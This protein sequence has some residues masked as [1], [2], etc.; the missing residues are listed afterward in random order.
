VLDAAAAAGG[1][2]QDP[3]LL[4]RRTILRKFTGEQVNTLLGG[5]A[6]GERAK[7]LKSLGCGGGGPCELLLVD[8]LLRPA[9][10]A[11]LDAGLHAGPLVGMDI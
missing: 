4:Y 10:A 9:A 11:A 1:S 5:V 2:S 8:C 3:S 7:A 6:V